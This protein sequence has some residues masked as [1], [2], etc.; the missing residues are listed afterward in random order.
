[1][2]FFCEYGDEP[3]V[4]INCEEFLDYQRASASQEG[5][6]SQELVRSYTTT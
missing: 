1:V 4:S 2:A 5:L 3:S 6:C